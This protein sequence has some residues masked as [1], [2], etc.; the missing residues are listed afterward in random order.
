MKG[1]Q[2]IREDECNRLVAKKPLIQEEIEKKDLIIYL[3]FILIDGEKASP[4]KICEMQNWAITSTLQKK[5]NEQKPQSIYLI[6][7]PD[8]IPSNCFS[9][10]CKI[11]IQF[12][13]K[14]FTVISAARISIYK[15]ISKTLTKYW[16]SAEPCKTCTNKMTIKWYTSPFIGTLKK[17]NYLQRILPIK[18]S[19]R[20]VTY[21]ARRRRNLKK[22]KMKINSKPVT[23]K[24]H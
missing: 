13:L 6:T 1:L 14:S 19:N 8:D 24:E 23:L 12:P 18:P 11:P 9:N 3:F 15:W 5:N 7:M 4:K 22:R 20:D 17:R 2:K 16:T 21:R 10:C